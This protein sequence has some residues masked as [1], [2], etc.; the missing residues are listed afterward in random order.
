M[1]IP[2]HNKEVN[3][4]KLY[5]FMREYSFVTLV[6]SKNDLIQATHLPVLVT[7]EESLIKISGHLAKA[8]HQWQTFSHSQEVLTI[9]Q[10]PHAYISPTNY[11]KFPSVPTWNYVAVHAYGVVKILHTQEEKLALINN[12]IKYYEATFLDHFNS[13][14]QEFIDKKLD[15]IVGFE[16]DVGRIESRYKLSQDRTVN[17][18]ETIIKT[19]TQTDDLLESSIARLMREN[20]TKTKH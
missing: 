14:P 7:M 10:Q 20:L 3:L 17:E 16:I 6:T 11:D 15:S 5:S 1:Y 18:Q 8:N 4:A 13:Y 9:F 2:N 19:L 12:M